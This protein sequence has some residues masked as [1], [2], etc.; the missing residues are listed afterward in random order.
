MPFVMQWR[1]AAAQECPVVNSTEIQV[2]HEKDTAAVGW[3]SS[4]AQCKGERTSVFTA[5]RGE[6]GPGFLVG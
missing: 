4:G 6:D 1:V 3:G 2:Y 5:N